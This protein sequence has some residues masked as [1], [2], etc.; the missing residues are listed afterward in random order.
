MKR[1]KKNN[2]KKI[3][4]ILI[5][6]VVVFAGIFVAKSVL[7]KEKAAPVAKVV[8]KLDKYGYTLEE[9]ATKYYKS[10]FNSLKK[11]LSKDSVDEEEYAKLVSQLFLADYFN[12]ENKISKNDVGGVQ[13]VYTPYQDSFM[14][15]SMD[16]VYRYVESDI[17]GDRKQELPVVTSVDVD[18]IK[19]VSHE[20]DGKTDEKA[21]SVDLSISYAKEMGYQ[22]NATLVLVHNKNKLE[23]VKM[24]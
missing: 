19:T 2:K 18:G 10:L 9:D 6:V 16:E 13:Y 22:T 1:K 4:I 5:A 20:Y 3:I 17:Y 11:T 14:K 21:Y 24:S 23:I 15:K 7:F 12:L 8:D